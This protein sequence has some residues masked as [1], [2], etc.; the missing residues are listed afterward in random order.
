MLRREIL[1]SPRI[2]HFTSQGVIY[3]CF[4]G[5]YSGFLRTGLH[6][7]RKN[8][9]RGA[10]ELSSPDICQAVNMLGQGGIGGL[11]HEPYITHDF[12]GTLPNRRRALR[13]GT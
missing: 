12:E 13:R 4:T 10:T 8:Y 9:F 5:V 6:L 7:G 3:D 11:F 2:V 1:F